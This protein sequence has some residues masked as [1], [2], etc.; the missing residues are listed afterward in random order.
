MRTIRFGR[1]LLAITV[2]AVVM[3]GCSASSSSPTPASTTSANRMTITR[4]SAGI[5]HITASNFRALGYGEALAFSEDNFCTLAQDFVT[6]NADRSKYFGPNSLSLK[7]SAGASD[8][9]LTSDFYW[10]SVKASGM[11][12]KE[13]HQSPPLGPFPQVLSVYNGFV[14]GYNAYLKSGK[15]KDPTCAGKAWVRPV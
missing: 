11:L 12:A 7:Y 2:V 9:N 13:L 1:E 4:D 10:Q 8:T 5:P 14:S 6:V 3:A 15:L